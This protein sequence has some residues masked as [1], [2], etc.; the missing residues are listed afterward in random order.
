MNKPTK[1]QKEAVANRAKELTKSQS[2][3]LR[4]GAPA[5][6]PLVENL[7]ETKPRT[8]YSSH[9]GPLPDP[10]TLAAYREIDEDLFRAVVEEFKENGKARR[11]TVDRQLAIDEK[12]MPGFHKLDAWGL[13]LSF[14]V[15]MS[16]LSLLAYAISKGDT[17]GAIIGGIATAILGLPALLRAMRGGRPKPIDDGEEQ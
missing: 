12:M 7:P 13:G 1:A 16:A 11:S 5:K 4:S 3:D 8:F 15:A 2:N 9:S 14:V 17:T 6:P 10:H